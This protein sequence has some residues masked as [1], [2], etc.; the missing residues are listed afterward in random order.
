MSA[1]VYF[2]KA[3]LKD[4]QKK[5]SDKAVKLFKAGNFSKCFK[6]NDFTAVK[7]HVGERTNTTYIKAPCFKGLI[8]KLRK[9]N[10]KAFLT[11]TSTLY[12]G[13]RYNAVDHCSHAAEHGFDIKGL[14]AP[15]IPP[16]GL[17]GTS[18]T[19]V[20]I[21]AALNKTVSIAYDIERC[22]S[23][24]SLS[25]LT[26]HDAAGI[27]AT[28]KNI[29]MGCASRKGKMRQHASVKPQITIRCTKCG[30]CIKHCL[31]K[32]ISM[33]KKIAYINPKKCVGC[34][35]CVAV[36]RFKA[37]S[38]DWE[39]ENKT[40]QKNVAEH[41]LGVLKGKENRAVFFN[42]IISVTEDCDCFKRPN[43]KKITPDVGIAA[44]TDPVA[45]D[46]ASIDLI[47]E[48]T[49]K[50]IQKLLK[51]S[52]LSPFFQIKHAEKIGLGT[53]DYQLIEVNL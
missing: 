9:L 42:F 43:M 32:A 22:Q 6:K 27:G 52:G 15:F 34:A 40:L 28:L 46:K 5:I 31:V 8:E 37:V 17:M 16:D 53:S 3:S 18:E 21:D 45:V 41:A 2:I 33:R 30:E 19:T 35:E 12:T 47:E 1:K 20:R 36:C 29:G 51:R 7:V 26:G 10:T 23:I 50:K 38:Y 4:G 49:D 24:L 25:H 13:R 48:R 44:S 14:G 11:D 39:V